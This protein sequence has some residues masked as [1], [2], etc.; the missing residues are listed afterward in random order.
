[1]TKGCATYPSKY[2]S[3]SPVTGMTF[4]PLAIDPYMGRQ[5]PSRHDVAYGPCVG[6]SFTCTGN[7]VETVDPRCMADQAA[8]FTLA[9]LC[10]ACA[11]HLVATIDWSGLAAS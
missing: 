10:A 9:V 4:G 7:G 3:G 6:I 2:F 5:A 1:M 8:A 11:S